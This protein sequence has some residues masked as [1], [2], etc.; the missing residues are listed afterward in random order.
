[1]R[2]VT[3]KRAAAASEVAASSE[4][5]GPKITASDRE[6]TELLIGLRDM[7]AQRSQMTAEWA[8]FL[9]ANEN[10]AAFEK[11]I[12]ERYGVTPPL[13]ILEDGTLKTDG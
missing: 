12:A 11:E 3:K 4:N 9:Q 5:T 13:R 7:W 6:R 10:L 2:H 8:R 1:M